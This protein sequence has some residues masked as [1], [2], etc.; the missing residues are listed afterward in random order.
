[1]KKFV[2]TSSVKKVFRPS[3]GPKKIVK[4]APR[5]EEYEEEVEEEEEEEAPRKVKKK[6]SRYE[7]EEESEEETEE[8]EVEEEEEE[9]APRKVKKK[10]SRYEE[11]EE[12]TEEEE[13]EEEEE[14]PRKVK[15]KVSRQEVE[16]EEEESEEETEE[17]EGEEEEA[18]EEDED[19]P[20]KVKTR[21]GK[22]GKESM[23]FLITDPNEIEEERE[24]A[25]QGQKMRPFLRIEAGKVAKVIFRS[26]TP[27]FVYHQHYVKMG[28]QGEYHTCT[29]QPECPLCAVGKQA[30]RTTKVVWEVVDLV[31]YVNKENKR[32]RYQVRFLELSGKFATQLK[33][34][35]A[36]AKSN[37]K[38]YP[39]SKTPL[40]ITKTGEQ[41]STAYNFR[42]GEPLE[43][44]HP[45]LRK[46]EWI[47]QED[48]VEM[49][50]PNESEMLRLAKRLGF[51]PSSD[52][53]SSW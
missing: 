9:E 16:E 52:G 19:A 34:V 46:P 15:K 1:M 48:V 23:S 5:E 31:G 45:K 39:L 51:D 35:L 8:E 42:F 12:E 22:S 6:V 40:L 17:E 38:R 2:K 47:S 3:S 27:R 33:E 18:E 10:V 36:D 24:R 49:Y 21:V 30:R 44:I 32:I 26:V 37:P 4:R 29:Q 41:T 53:D 50:S 43:E 7:E 14:A 25:T 13:V 20:R 11:E 28:K